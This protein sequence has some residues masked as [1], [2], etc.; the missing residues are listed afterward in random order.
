MTVRKKDIAEY[1]GV[2]RAAVSLALNNTPGSTISQE[3]RNKILQAASELGYKDFVSS[4]QIGFILYNRE[5]DDPRY[6]CILKEIEKTLKE[7]HCNLLFMNISSLPL[8]HLNLRQ[9]LASQKVKGIIVSGDMDDT[10]IELIEDSGIPYVIYGGSA[11][12]DLHMVIPDHRKAAYE[13]VKY[14]IRLGHRKIALFNGSLDLEIHKLS[15]EGYQQALEDFGVEVNK[16]LVQIGKEEDGYEM[17]GR[18]EALK[19]EYS[20]VFCVNTII[21]FGALQRLKE[22]GVK[23][24]AE[25]SLIGYGYTELIHISIPQLTAV[26]VEQSA[27]R[28]VRRLMDI[29][30]NQN[31]KKE[32]LYLSEMSFFDGGTCALH[33]EKQE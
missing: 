23:I 2:S 20:A 31:R 19:I 17:C 25:K 7:F 21:Q 10:I 33:R 9:F 15:L 11:R 24:P 12:E 8:E 1:L 5:S 32:V 28:P 30:Q 27:E 13:A 18:M 6:I 16:E 14:L 29:I 22:M 26:F 4:D 3:T